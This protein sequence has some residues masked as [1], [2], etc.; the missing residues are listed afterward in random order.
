MFIDCDI[1]NE[2][3]SICFKVHDPRT[4]AN[5]LA[6]LCG[7]ISAVRCLALKS[8]KLMDDAGFVVGWSATA[9]YCGPIDYLALVWEAAERCQ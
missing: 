2:E 8:A 9:D 3:I 7:T 4:N 6:E 5:W 1:L